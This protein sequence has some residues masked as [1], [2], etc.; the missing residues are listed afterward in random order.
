[1]MTHKPYEFF[2]R[3]GNKHYNDSPYWNIAILSTFNPMEFVES[4]MNVKNHDKHTIITAISDRY[5]W[6][7][8]TD[9]SAKYQLKELYNELPFLKEVYK[10]VESKLEQS[11]MSPS[12][13]Y[14]K[15]LREKLSILIENLIDFEVFIRKYELERDSKAETSSVADIPE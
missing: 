2:E 5:Q 3:I 4:F 14:L 12:I 9:P 1:L 7:Q 15:V 10:L 6:I 8:K 11:A 13:G